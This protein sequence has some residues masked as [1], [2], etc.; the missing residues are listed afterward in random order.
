MV[1]HN[2][3]AHRPNRIGIEGVTDRWS[4]RED[5]DITLAGQ[6]QAERDGTTLSEIMRTAGRAYLEE[7]GWNVDHLMSKDQDVVDAEWTA[8]LDCRAPRTRKRHAP[9]RVTDVEIDPGGTIELF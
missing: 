5:K 8:R 7:R 1:D 4:F 2:G 6:A 9:R 3:V